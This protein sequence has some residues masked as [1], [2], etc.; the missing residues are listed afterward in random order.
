MPRENIQDQLS[1][2]DDT[3]RR[4][5][6]DIALL[7]RRKVAIENNQRSVFG[8][9]FGQNFIELAAADERGRIG[10]VA[11]LEEGSG[12]GCTC[13]PRQLN[14]LG[15][16]LAFRRASGNSTHAWRTFPGDADEKSTFSRGNGL[17]GFHR[18]R[19][20]ARPAI[21]ESRNLSGRTLPSIRL[22][23]ERREIA[24][25]HGTA[26][27]GCSSYAFAVSTACPKTIRFPSGASTSNSLC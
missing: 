8:I 19:S 10:F 2:I 23:H 27:R 26:G 5:L 24:G 9:G 12:D 14:Q 11:Q 7:H 13:A 6:F 17:R 20:E 22:M 4:V 15:E 18:A 16:R 3:A 21:L 25:D 1:A